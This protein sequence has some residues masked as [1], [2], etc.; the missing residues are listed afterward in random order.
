M[1]IN[2]KYKNIHRRDNS[3]R[4]LGPEPLRSIQSQS[5]TIQ[6]P[7]HGSTYIEHKNLT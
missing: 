4:I 7:Q 5:V 6:I 1:V 2:Y 3:F